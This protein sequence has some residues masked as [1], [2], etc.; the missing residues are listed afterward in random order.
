MPQ[1]AKKVFE[2]LIFDVYQ[3]R[4]LMFDG[5]YATFEKLSRTDSAIVVA[6]TADKNIIVLNE[7][8]PT[9]PPFLASPGGRLDEG[10]DALA[11]AKRE[12]MEETGYES[13]RW[14]LWYSI[15]PYSKIDWTIFVYIAK[16]CH[17]VAEPKLDAGE[18]IELKL[19]SFKEWLELAA[20]ETLRENDLTVIALKAQLDQK[21]MAD[22]KLRLGV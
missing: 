22:L 10:E 6:I 7:Q 14:E 12:L 1:N 3:W 5:S 13:N 17:K 18:K 11:G 2:G 9:K 21:V 16:N 15:Q 19:V 20:G 4:Q 8:Q